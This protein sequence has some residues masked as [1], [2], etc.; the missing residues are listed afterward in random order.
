MEL[1]MLVPQRVPSMS[2]SHP[3][4]PGRFGRKGSW[5]KKLFSGVCMRMRGWFEA[6]CFCPIHPSWEENM[7]GATAVLWSDVIKSKKKKMTQ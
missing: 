2:L 7:P 1:G 5:G 3:Y 4:S 6:W